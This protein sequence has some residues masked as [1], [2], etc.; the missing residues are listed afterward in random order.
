MQRG[1]KPVLSNP[2]ILH[3]VPYQLRFVFIVV[4]SPLSKKRNASKEMAAT[5]RNLLGLWGEIFW[6]E[7]ISLS[8]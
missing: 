2:S 1:M 4:F 6:M 8:F 7:L 3:S 5:R